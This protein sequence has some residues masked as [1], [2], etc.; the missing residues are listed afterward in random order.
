MKRRADNQ[1]DRQRQDGCSVKDTCLFFVGD[2]V[3]WSKCSGG[4]A[5]ACVFLPT[6]RLHTTPPSAPGERFEALAARL[7][8]DPPIDPIDWNV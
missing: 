5:T 1:R 8:L 7:L 6:N 2:A 3:I 4:T